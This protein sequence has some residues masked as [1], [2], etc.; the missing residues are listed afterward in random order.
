MLNKDN[1]KKLLGKCWAKTRDYSRVCSILQEIIF[2][3]I[4]L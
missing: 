2:W 1:F 4:G 3:R